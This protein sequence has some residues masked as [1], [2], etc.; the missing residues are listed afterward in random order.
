M[1]SEKDEK[2]EQ[3]KKKVAIALDSCMSTQSLDIITTSTARP[4]PPPSLTI[5]HASKSKIL[6]TSSMQ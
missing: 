5:Y 6:D 3:M 2:K 4:T 1:Q